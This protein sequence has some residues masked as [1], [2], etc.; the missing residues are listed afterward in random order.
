MNPVSTESTVGTVGSEPT[1]R[2]KL[3]MDLDRQVVSFQETIAR[4]ATKFKAHDV[5]HSIRIENLKAFILMLRDSEGQLTD[6]E[7]D[8]VL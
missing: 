8:G 1:E 2:S 6:M 4:C 7:A 3:Y 5:E